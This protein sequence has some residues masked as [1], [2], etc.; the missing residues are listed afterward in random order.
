[1]KPILAIIGSAFVAACGASQ[2]EPTDPVTVEVVVCDPELG[3]TAGQYLRLAN[4]RRR[5]GVC[6][7]IL[8]SSGYR[9]QEIRFIAESDAARLEHEFDTY[10]ISGRI[11]CYNGPVFRELQRLVEEKRQNGTLCREP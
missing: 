11:D 6:E 4:W 7:A 8:E 5:E 2:L 10:Q 9:Q 3:G 1:M